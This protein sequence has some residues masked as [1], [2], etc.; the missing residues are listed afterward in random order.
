MKRPIP[1]NVVNAFDEEANSIWADRHG[2]DLFFVLPSPLKPGEPA[3]IYVNP[4]RSENLANKEPVVIVGGFDGWSN[5]NF[6]LTTSRA[7]IPQFADVRWQTAKVNVPKDA[8]DDLQMV[9][10]DERKEIYDNNDEQN[11]TVWL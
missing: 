11:Y 8:R 4:Q 9:F 2:A 5:G 1:E 7:P 6:E 3:A 10:A